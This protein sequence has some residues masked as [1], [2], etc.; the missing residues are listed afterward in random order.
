MSAIEPGYSLL[1]LLLAFAIGIVIGRVTA[2]G[3][4]ER[5]AQEASS[6]TIALPSAELRTEIE[7]LLA[8]DRKI[9]AIRVARAALGLG[10]KEAKDLV[11]SLEPSNAS[12]GARVS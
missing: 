2:G 11:E 6:D 9:E 5:H 12:G 7:T 8:D 3:R 1:T 10:L 4:R